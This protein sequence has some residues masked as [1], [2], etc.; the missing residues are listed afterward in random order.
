MAAAVPARPAAAPAGVKPSELVWMRQ[1]L[2]L[3]APAPELIV[4]VGS[5][6]FEELFVPMLCTG[7][8]TWGGA[9]VSDSTAAAAAPPQGGA[10]APP[11]GPPDAA[12][13]TTANVGAHCGAL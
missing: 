5:V 10:S 4:P 9:T 3:R 2:D 1:R 7:D 12:Q 13:A 8:A 11:G 6:A